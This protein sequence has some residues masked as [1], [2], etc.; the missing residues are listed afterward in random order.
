MDRQIALK[1]NKSE[2]FSIFYLIYTKLDGE[3]PEFSIEGQWFDNGI[4]LNPIDNPKKM[5]V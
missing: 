3:F 4:D 1:Q 5:A 2:P